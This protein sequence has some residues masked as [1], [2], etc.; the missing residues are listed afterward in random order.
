[1]HCLQIVLWVTYR[2]NKATQNKKEIAKNNDREQPRPAFTLFEIECLLFNSNRYLQVRLGTFIDG[3]AFAKRHRF[4]AKSHDATHNIL[5]IS[6]TLKFENVKSTQIY[7]SSR[8]AVIHVASPK[9][10][11]G[12]R[13]G[14]LNMFS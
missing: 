4:S 5:S 11:Q 8:T 3:W 10:C 14:Q 1:M 7:T 9:N 2:N 13:Y 6:M 12:E